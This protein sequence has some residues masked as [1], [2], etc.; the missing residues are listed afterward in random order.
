LYSTRNGK[1]LNR[2]LNWRKSA[3]EVIAMKNVKSLDL[4]K[5]KYVVEKSHN[6]YLLDESLMSFKEAV[7]GYDSKFD[8]IKDIRN[9]NSDV[10]IISS[11]KDLVRNFPG[12]NFSNLE[13]AKKSID[14]ALY[15]ANNLVNSGKTVVFT[16][17]LF[18]IKPE[19][20][21]EAT[22]TTTKTSSQITE[23]ADG[24]KIIDNALTQS[25]EKEIFEMLKPWIEQQASKT[26]KGAS[27]PLMI[28]L[29]LRWDYTSNNPG[30]KPVYIK[31]TIVNST[32]QRN[33]YAYY[34]VSIDGEPLGEIPNR[35]KQLMTK[36]TGIDAT[37]YDGA[38]INLYQKESF[39]SA[40]NDVD[41]SITAI[42]YPVLVANI[43]G[44]GSLSVEGAESQKSKKPYNKKEYLDKDLKS[45][46]AYIFGEDSK[47]RDVYHRTLS[48]TG[49]G[50]LPELNV[51]GQ[52]IPANSYRIS[53]TLRRVMD[54]EPGMP[55]APAKLTT[56]K[57]ISNAKN[58]NKKNLFT[59]TP[60]KGVSDKKAKVKASIATQYIGFGE[61]IVGKDGKRSSTQ[62]YR[63]QAGALANTGNYS[64]NDVIFVSVPGLR[65]NA[66]IVKRE[67]DK[68]IKEAIKAL[69]AG[70]TILTD[71]KTYTEGSE[72]NTGEQRLYK[73]L[74][75][76][77]D[78][79]YS[80]IPIDGQVLGTWSKPTAQPSTT[81]KPTTEI[82]K[83]LQDK[84]N[85]ANLEKE[86]YEISLVND[87]PTIVR[88][89][90]LPKK[91]KKGYSVFYSDFSNKLGLIKRV[92]K[93]V[94][95]PGFE[96]VQLMM[97]QDTNDIFELTTG[98]LIPTKETTQSKILEE[99]K[100]LFAEKNVREVIKNV[101]KINAND[102]NTKITSLTSQSTEASTGIKPTIDLS[103]EWRG[104]LESRPVYTKE[105]IN[106]MRTTSAKPNEHFGNPFS[107]AGYGNTI[108]VESISDAVQAYKDWLLHGVTFYVSASALAPF[109]A[110]RQWILD[111]INKGKLDGATLLYAGKSAARGQGMH[112][113]ALAE[114]V[115]EL[116]GDQ[117]SK[118]KVDELSVYLSNKMNQNFNIDNPNYTGGPSIDNIVTN[119]VPTNQ[120]DI[121][122]KKEEC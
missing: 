98:R 54:L 92:G 49:K 84:I 105:G 109:E 73:N 18:D 9:S 104:D 114:V 39:I 87:V 51:K 75:A 44:P 56:T 37:N 103:R 90:E 97:E 48:D 29:N 30:K 117:S 107:E 17:S 110:Q 64:S 94:V 41:E 106:T 102:A 63:E 2:G 55:T 67:Q 16:S 58:F 7:E 24:I 35:L 45:G 47:N 71:N 42:N 93:K 4:S 86:D 88:I 8:L 80:E 66:E 14:S 62:I 120:Q 74:E 100:K 1:V 122:N 95:I 83:E 57:P 99:L 119:H 77:K 65:G 19:S 61:D 68:T 11:L 40:H 60:Q 13:Q 101:S 72:Y 10:I 6:V 89:T 31:E 121:D 28:G 3:A 20:L 33:K 5:L 26:N 23:V 43:G 52:I 15:Y 69:E 59:V 108:K 96:D 25:E 46:S 91:I 12:L 76:K 22:E 70:A 112:P 79:Q 53:V 36:A 115:E 78:Y 118:E 38:I 34:N 27:A 32:A 81:I 21:V 82:S 50:N 111:Q 85:A 116:R 113:T